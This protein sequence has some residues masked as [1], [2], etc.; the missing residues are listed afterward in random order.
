[1]KRFKAGKEYYTLPGGGVERNETLEAA[2]IRETAEETSIIIDNPKLVFVEQAEAPFGPQNI[3]LCHY[4]SG[5]P[6]LPPTSEEAFWSTPGMNTYEPLW[7]PIDE[8]KKVPF[9]SELLKRAVLDGLEKGFPETPYNFSSKHS[10]RL[11]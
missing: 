9:V 3:F 2:A 10:S 1:M 6:Y 4:I 5:E 8:L 11:S 7:L